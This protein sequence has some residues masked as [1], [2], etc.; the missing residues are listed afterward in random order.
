V[1]DATGLVR[2]AGRIAS[3]EAIRARSLDGVRLRYAGNRTPLGVL[4]ERRPYS[5]DNQSGTE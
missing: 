2:K 1:V 5:G 3:V 4:A